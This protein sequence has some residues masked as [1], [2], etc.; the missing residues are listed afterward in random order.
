MNPAAL[1][2]NS[3]QRYLQ[4]EIGTREWGRMSRG[5]QCGFKNILVSRTLKFSNESIEASSEE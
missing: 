1:E 2:I 4:L 5:V 3:Q